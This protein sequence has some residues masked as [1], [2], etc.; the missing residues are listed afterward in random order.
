V[1]KI[2]MHL[3]SETGA[4]GAPLMRYLF[5]GIAIIFMMILSSCVAT[6][7]RLIA[8]LQQSSV[9]EI[10]IETAPD[11]KMTGLFTEGKPD[12][13]LA[14]VVRVLKGTMEKDL[15]GLPGGPTPARLV[16]SLHVVDLAT[17]A[18]RILIHSDSQISGMVR[19]ED[20][21]TGHLIA[22]Q[23]IAAGNSG[24]RGEGLG[25]IVAMAVNAASTAGPDDIL[26]QRL[27]NAFTQQVKQWLLTK[28]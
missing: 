24:M 28:K 3:T 7:P 4:S 1:V 22:E 17:K 18:G 20:V 11:V 16:V 9:R 10:R 19:L 6:D 21:K 23:P 14:T 8:A 5:G 27:S 2:Y 15:T 12:P 25:I 26:A 13:Q